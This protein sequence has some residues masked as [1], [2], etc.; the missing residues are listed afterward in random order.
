MNNCCIDHNYFRA[1]QGVIGAKDEQELLRLE[2]QMQWADEFDDSFG[3]EKALRN[4]KPQD[5]IF[6]STEEDN[7]FTVF[8]RPGEEINIGD[9][10]YWGKMH[11]L[12]RVKDFNSAVFNSA[13]IVC[14]NRQIMWQNPDTKEIVTRWCFA[15]K[16]YTSNVDEGNVV[17]LLH[18]RYDIELP[19]D[20]ETIAVPVGKRFMLDIVGGHPMCYKLVFPDVNTNKYQDS[21][22][23]FIEWNLESDEYQKDNDRVDLMICNYLEPDIPTPDTN[24]IRSA[25]T[26]REEL[27]LGGRRKYTA[28]LYSHDNAML[29]ADIYE[30]TWELE[31]DES[32][33][34]YFHLEQ[35]QEICYLSC[36]MR[37]SLVGS[38][39]TLRLN[40]NDVLTENAAIQIKVVSA[41]G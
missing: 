27:K 15:S 9:I 18:G 34:S 30:L 5:F 26:G 16:P 1:V 37:E 19:Y 22:G 17:T 20:E 32:I 23:G 35:D 36:D 28:E 14:C 11:W 29:P 41:F 40:C 12:V 8:T 4:D 24:L 39:V 10:L 25:I 6:K 2:R 7:Q 3:Y 33:A 13:T 31:A 21:V 38:V